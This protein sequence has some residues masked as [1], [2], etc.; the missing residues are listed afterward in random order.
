MNGFL[1]IM[2]LVQDPTLMLAI[3]SRMAKKPQVTFNKLYPK[4]YNAHLWVM[5]YERIAP[6]PG[7]M[8]PGVDGMTID[9]MGLALI[10]DLIDD[11]KRSRYV[12]KPARR[13]YIPK[14][15]GK[16]RP[17][18]IPSFQDKLVQTVLNFILEAIYEPTFSP[19]SHGFRPNRSCHTALQAVRGMNGTRWWVEGDI[20]GFFDHLQHDT[21]L[22]ILGKRITDKRFL[23]LIRQ[24]LEAG[25]LEE[26]RFHRTYSGTPQGGNLSPLLAN[27][28]LNELDQAI[29]AKAVEFNRGR[30]RRQN[31]AYNV[32]HTAMTRARKRARC[33]RD[34]MQFKRLQ[35]KL[36][37]L[38]A[39]DAQDE[40][41]RRLTYVRY[42]DDF[43]LGIIGS[44]ADADAVKHWLGAFLRDELGLELSPEKTLVTN[45]KDPIRFLGYDIRRWNRVRILRYP[46]KTGMCTKRTTTQQLVLLLPPDK[47]RAFARTY[48]NPTGWQGK[49]RSNLIALSDLEIL[50]LFNAEVRGFLGYY[51]LAANLKLVG[52]NLLW[53]TTGSFFR[54][55]AGKH[56]SSLAKIASR[57]KRGPGHFVITVQK[58]NGTTKDYALVAST[59]QLLQGISQYPALDLYPNTMKYRGRTELGNR[60]LANQCE[61]CG[62]RDGLMEVHHVRKLG[63]LTGKTLWERQ[64][65]ERRRKT[66]VLCAQCHDELYAGRLRPKRTYSGKTGEPDT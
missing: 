31:S 9:G 4:L 49:H 41:F 5:V 18:G 45:A 66:M 16:R 23:H 19:A 14:A 60:L 50:L 1:L 64:M 36:L 33:T 27:I 10:R 26:W 21:L 40:T 44:K 39:T 55:L 42:A 30:K 62:R 58:G 51:A 28:Y 12:P 2:C 15:N 56:R 8:T 13:I 59:K 11:L 43:V 52:A 54:T 46:A 65:I 35:R 6:K 63:A 48:G 47:C 25:Y 20:T 17:L 29:H 38:P 61:W 53:L 3:L 32:T 24:L 37:S 57:M 7:N 22:R 34:W